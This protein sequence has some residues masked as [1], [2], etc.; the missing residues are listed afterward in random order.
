MKKFTVLLSFVL[1]A[2]VGAFATYKL[3]EK[4]FKDIADEEIK[5]VIEK[6]KEREKQLTSKKPDKKSGVPS[7]DTYAEPVTP[8]SLG[9][10]NAAVEEKPKNISIISP[11]EFGEY[12]D[13]ETVSLTYY[14]DGVLTDQ[15][16]NIIDNVED[17]VG[18]GFETHFGEYEDDSV[19]VRN[20]DKTIDFEILRDNRTYQEVVLGEKP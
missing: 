20:D 10:T 7:W 2:G 9:Y 11:D 18:K 5:S 14:A 19:F 1:G 8:K 16:D 12:S 3:V 4:H 13:Y 17:Y 15:M 6:F